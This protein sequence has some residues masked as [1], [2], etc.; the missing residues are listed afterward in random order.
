MT[1]ILALILLIVASAAPLG[2]GHAPAIEE[3]VFLPEG[4][5]NRSD[6][7]IQFNAFS[8]DSA[9]GLE[10]VHEWA[11][12]GERHQFGYT[13]PIFNEAGTT[14]LGDASLNY[15]YQIFGR[16]DSAVAVAPRV[17]L[18]LPTRS[19]HFGERESGLELA[20]P[21]SVAL[22]E[23]TVSHSR[24]LAKWTVAG[25]RPELRLA[26]GLAFSPVPRLSLSVDAEYLLNDAGGLRYR[27]SV[28]LNLEGPAGL[29]WSPGVAFPSD[30]GRPGVLL[31]VAIEHPFGR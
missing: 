28:Q 1:R 17:S 15:R 9:F 16:G 14:G 2:G 21:I 31:Y 8:I 12:S 3:H 23:R 30:G 7:V 24:G 22:G 4:A 27:P 5:W 10:L 26:Q 11:G 19:A 20:L 18:V 13:L 29:R 6:R 25:G